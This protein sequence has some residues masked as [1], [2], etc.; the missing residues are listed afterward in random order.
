[1]K[2]VIFILFTLLL[3]FT[4]SA[5]LSADELVNESDEINSVEVVSAQDNYNLTFEVFNHSFEN[6]GFYKGLS[7]EMNWVNHIEILIEEDEE[8]GQ[9]WIDN[10]EEL[11]GGP[12]HHYSSGL[13]SVFKGDNLREEPLFYQNGEFKAEILD[14]GEYY[15]V[16][17]PAESPNRYL[18]EQGECFIYHNVTD[19]E[20]F[21][22]V[23]ECPDDT[24]DYYILLAGGISLFVI[25]YSGYRSLPL[26]RRKLILRRLNKLTE[27]VEKSEKYEKNTLE[28]LIQANRE[29]QNHNL[30]KASGLLDDIERQVG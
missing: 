23:D 17:L 18:N 19:E 16:I 20:D 11:Y 12:G 9:N 7:V 4:T 13:M 2:K 14:S 25:L 24:F 26:L 28:E 30:D 8:W 10:N 3:V 21:Q 29:I 1:M 22:P 15:F 5:N 6:Y 27:R